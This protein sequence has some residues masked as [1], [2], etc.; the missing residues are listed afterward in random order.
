VV[1][2]L[3]NVAGTVTAFWHAAVPEHSDTFVGDT[4]FSV[5]PVAGLIEPTQELAFIAWNLILEVPVL[6]L[7]AAGVAEAGEAGPNDTL[8]ELPLPQPAPLELV[9][10]A[11]R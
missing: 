2:S 4:P 8:P 10:V 11:C 6:E 9:A 5:A 7:R 1:L 3:S